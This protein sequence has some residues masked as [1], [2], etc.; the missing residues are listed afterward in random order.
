MYIKHLPC[1]RYFIKRNDREMRIGPISNVKLV[2]RKCDMAFLLELAPSFSLKFHYSFSVKLCPLSA[3]LGNVYV[4]CKPGQH[5]PLLHFYQP[6]ASFE[7]TASS[8]TP[9][10]SDCKEKG[11]DGQKLP[12]TQAWLTHPLIQDG[13]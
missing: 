13:Q 3:I 10:S 5:F 8:P 9:S 1:G 6:L 2:M 11:E 4:F 12:M 7:G